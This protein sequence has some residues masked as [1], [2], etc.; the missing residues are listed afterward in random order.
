M[1][2][3]TVFLLFFVTD[4][5]FAQDTKPTSPA[6]ADSVWKHM[7]I[8]STNITQVSFTDWAQ[9]GENALAYTLFLEGKSTY[10]F[11]MINWINS[12]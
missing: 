12:Y 1:K 5:T 11:D 8:M 3:L 4:I 9:G 2:I 6:S 7:M 10:A